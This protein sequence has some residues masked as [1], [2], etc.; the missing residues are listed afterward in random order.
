MRLIKSNTD[1]VD[2]AL[3]DFSKKFRN[4][5]ASYEPLELDDF[6]SDDLEK[7]ADATD[8]MLRA[9]DWLSQTAS[10]FKDIIDAKVDAL[11]IEG[12]RD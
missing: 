7:L 1:R 12:P 4:V 5:I 8:A 9:A 10:Q 11:Y 6:D 2:R 3:V